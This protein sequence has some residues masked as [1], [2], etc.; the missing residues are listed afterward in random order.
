M[1][2]IFE[3]DPAES[4]KMNQHSEC[5]DHSSFNSESIILTHRQ[6]HKP[7]PLLYLNY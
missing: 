3:L 4:V 5:L 2:A 1:T 7:D 6:V